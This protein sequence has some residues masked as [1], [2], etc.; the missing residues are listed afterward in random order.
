[1][2]TPGDIGATLSL[3]VTATGPGGSQTATTTATAVVGAAP[4]PAAVPGSLLEQPG[5]AGAVVTTDGRATVTWQPG[6]IPDGATVTL[7]PGERAPALKGTGVTVGVSGATILPWPVDVAFA[8]APP[9]GSVV[10]YSLDSTIWRPAQ[11]LAG[12]VLPAGDVAGT[13]TD[14]NGVFH[15]LVD[16]PVHLAAFAGGRWGDPSLVSAGLP[17]VYR[18]GPLTVK[19]LADGSV[20]IRARVSVASQA[21][22]FVGLAGGA[23][24]E[25]LLLHPGS[26]PITLRVHLKR[27]VATRL[28]VAAVDPFKRHAVL[29]LPFRAP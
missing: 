15:V 29:L 9:A 23:T 2:L 22:L 10:G 21:H 27:G 4:V 3:V 8:A 18:N 1:V 16:Q 28:R 11:A 24:R 20:L 25:S 19:R 7:A 6:A 26:V 12:P 17:T 14:T 13:Y 5:L